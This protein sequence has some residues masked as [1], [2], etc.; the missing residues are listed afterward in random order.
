M[1]GV[2]P[3]F[4]FKIIHMNNNILKSIIRDSGYIIP[5]VLKIYTDLFHSDITIITL[6]EIKKD[7]K[8]SGFN[9]D[10]EIEKKSS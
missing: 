9:F 10:S 8:F 6:E 4:L 3:S 7:Y 1:G 5:E 2:A